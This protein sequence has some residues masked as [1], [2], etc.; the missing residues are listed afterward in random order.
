[1]RVVIGLI[2]LLRLKHWIKNFLVF[3]PPFFLGVLFQK[4]NI[5]LGALSF[6]SFSCIASAVYVV[7]DIKDCERDRQHPTKRIRPI[8][9][10]DVPVAIAWVLFA[11]LVL[12]G[13][14]PSVL[15]KMPI[16]S[17]VV[18]IA[19]LVVNVCYSF[20]LKNIPIVEIF[21]LAS[22]FVFRIFYGGFFVGV[23][24]SS[25]L[26]LCVFSGAVFLALGKRRN[27]K[28]K[29]VSGGETRPVLQAYGMRF[30]DSSY[31]LFCTMTVVF[32]SLWTIS[33]TDQHAVGKL[34]F[35]IPFLFF[36]I[37]R[38]NLIVDSEESDGDPVPVLLK[39]H[40]LTV[41]VLAFVAINFVV[42]YLGQYLPRMTYQL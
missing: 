3:V 4:D 32:Y 31:Y 15:S 42:V 13:L 39:D 10:G 5:I 21:I 20:G 27:E 16:C 8:A 6:V 22:G 7:N 12:C 25:W 28:I 14:A 33:R 17:S 9:H 41:S 18:V 29:M 37:V 40:W 30:L 11:C 36:I 38:Y 35:T 1:M 26:F 23:P 2:R 34:A 24:V 19:Y